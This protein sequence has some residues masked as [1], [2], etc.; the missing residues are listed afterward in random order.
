MRKIP[1]R[2]LV[3]CYSWV[4]CLDVSETVLSTFQLSL[5]YFQGGLHFR[6]PRLIFIQLG[7]K[8]AVAARIILWLF[9]RCVS[10]FWSTINCRSLCSR[11]V[12]K[13]VPGCCS[14][15]SW[16]FPLDDMRTHGLM[17]APG[18]SVVLGNLFFPWQ[19]FPKNVLSKNTNM[20]V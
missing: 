3:M 2:K 5:F 6:N 12:T 11:C 16:S 17:K 14:H 19:L 8:W 18:S 20:R 10:F 9:E 4:S 15:S 13:H 7:V 1:F